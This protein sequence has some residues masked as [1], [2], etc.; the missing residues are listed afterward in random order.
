[1]SKW[2]RNERKPTD[3]GLHKLLVA[4]FTRISNSMRKFYENLSK[5]S[6]QVL[7]SEIFILTSNKSQYIWNFERNYLHN[8]G[9]LPYCAACFQLP[10]DMTLHPAIATTV[11]HPFRL[12][13]PLKFGPPSWSFRAEKR[14]YWLSARSVLLQHISQDFKAVAQLLST[15]FHLRGQTPS[16]WRKTRFLCVGHPTVTYSNH[17]EI[18]TK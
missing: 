1:M 12:I 16:C 11:S 14:W 10:A 15:S 5:M 8:W 2:I 6:C 7:F 13:I 18:G 4:R 17:R 3:L 9:T